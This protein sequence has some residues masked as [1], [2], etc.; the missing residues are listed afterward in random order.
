M[1]QGYKGKATEISQ[2]SKE[3]PLAYHTQNVHN[4]KRLAMLVTCTL[5]LMQPWTASFTNQA[6][7]ISNIE[8]HN[9]SRRDQEGLAPDLT[10][11]KHKQS[12]LFRTKDTWQNGQC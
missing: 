10:A 11:S 2:R 4:A 3:Q 8:Q 7:Y 6:G 5:Q 1:S 9:M 12:S